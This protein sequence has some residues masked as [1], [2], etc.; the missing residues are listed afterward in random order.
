MAAKLTAG[1]RL[2]V[3]SELALQM[4][5]QPG[6]QFD[7]VAGA[8]AVVEL[9]HENALPGVA[10][11]AG[12]ARQGEEIGA[13][14]DPGRRP[15]LDR[16][17]PDLVVAEPSEQLAKTGNLLLVDAVEGLG[18]DIAPGDA[19]DAGGDHDIDLGIGDPR[20]ELRDDLI[21]LVANNPPR[22][23]AMSGG[24]G[25]ICEGVCRIGPAPRRACRKPS[26]AE[27]H[28]LSTKWQPA[29]FI[30]NIFEAIH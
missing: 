15:A 24:G 26:S 2:A 28:W 19:G 12:R 25:E 4:L 27:C 7:K 23:Y 22:G 21:L 17:C 13:A 9:V 5:L 14:G 20:P 18:R 6:H 29:R 8:K 16:R 30:N 3:G 10:A 1:S 11:G